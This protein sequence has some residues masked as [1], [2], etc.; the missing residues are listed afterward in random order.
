MQH[1]WECL[2]NKLQVSYR[3]HKQKL[4]ND[5]LAKTG[6]DADKYADTSAAKFQRLNNVLASLKTD[7]GA[8][9]MDAITPLIPVVQGFLNVINGLPGPVKS[10]GFAAIALG[11]GIGIIAGPLTSV[12]G[13]MEMLGVSLPTIG[14]FMAALGGETAA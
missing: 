4:L 10:V 5:V 9:L 12:I 11:A 2:K 3:K 1:R 7:F 8:A 6:G 14:G 13:L